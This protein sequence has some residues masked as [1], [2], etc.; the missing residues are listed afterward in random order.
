MRVLSYIKSWD[1]GTQP[2]PLKEVYPLVLSC[3]CRDTYAQ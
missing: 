3:F 2:G 1:V